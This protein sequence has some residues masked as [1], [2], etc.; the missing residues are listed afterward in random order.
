LAKLIFCW[1]EF[2]N[3]SKKSNQ[4]FT[5]LALFEMYDDNGNVINS[6]FGGGQ[7]LT[8]YLF[9][10]LFIFIKPVKLLATNTSEFYQNIKNNAMLI[11]EC[12]QN[13]ARGLA[14]Y[15]S[16]IAKRR[17]ENGRWFNLSPK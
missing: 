16:I 3:S 14:D 9:E 2:S 11:L 15:S 4:Q 10:E 12:T 5:Q 7:D 1:T 6:W 13:E 17:N 8:P